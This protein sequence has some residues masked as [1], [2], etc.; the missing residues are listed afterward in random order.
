MAD[1]AVVV[2]ATE[3]K[4]VGFMRKLMK[5]AVIGAV[6]AA[7]VQVFKRRKGQDLDDVEWQ[8][9]PPPVGG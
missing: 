7:V 9:P 6:I 4:K 8:E 2:E 5:I 1:E 3:G